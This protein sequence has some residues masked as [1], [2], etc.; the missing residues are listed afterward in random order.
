ADKHI[1]DCRTEL[2][3]FMGTKPYEIV[4]EP[5]LKSGKKVYIVKRVT[6]VPALICAIAGDAL[7]NLRTALDYMAHGLV[8]AND[9]KV[10]SDTSFP[11]LKGDIGSEVY[12][13]AFDRKVDG[14][15]GD[16]IEKIKSL[17]PYK[18]G[19]DILWRL[20][21]MNIRDKHRLLVAGG[22]A[23]STFKPDPLEKRVN[24]SLEEIAQAFDD[25]IVMVLGAFPL[26]QGQEILVDPP[27]AEPDQN[28]G[29]L[30]EVA[31]SE[32]EKAAPISLVL[33][34]RRCRRRVWQI[35]VEFGQFLR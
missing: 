17:K 4:A 8:I 12:K 13:P 16:V 19:D 24:L 25:A 10:T 27:P 20:H 15:R 11:I 33:L 2:Q 18:G 31:V 23:V 28:V 3:R 9:G 35:L 21:A 29:L 6:P 30:G 22:C 14:M 1:H 7:Q 32:S 26:Y 34:L 5:N